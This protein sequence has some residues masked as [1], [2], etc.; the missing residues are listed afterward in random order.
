MS[1]EAK[2]KTKTYECVDV[3]SS[4]SSDGAN[5]LTLALTNVEDI[6]ELIEEATD[7]DHIEILEDGVVT[8]IFEDYIK[9]MSEAMAGDSVEISVCQPSLVQ[10]V[11]TL[12]ATVKAQAKVIADQEATIKEQEQTIN[13]QTEQ[14]ASLQESQEV[15]DGYIDYI[16]MMTDVDLPTEDDG[17]GE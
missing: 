8:Q 13:Q 6:N 4:Y 10:Q 14:I 9:F 7:C 15:Q 5:E 11:V 17:E 12:K 1:Q 3:R 2:F 16:S